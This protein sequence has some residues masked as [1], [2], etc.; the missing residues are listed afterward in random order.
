MWQTKGHNIPIEFIKHSIVSNRLAHAYLISGASYIGKTTFAL[1]IAKVVNCL[2]VQ[3]DHSPCEECRNCVRI[4]TRNH[5]DIH[6][7][8]FL[9]SK[10]SPIDQLREDFLAQVYKKPYEGKYK[11]FIISHIDKMRSEHS[12]LLLKTL[13]EPPE[14]V[15]IILIS[16]NKSKILGTILSRCQILDLY[17]ISDISLLK[18][19]TTMSNLSLSDNLDIELIVRL[20]R[21]RIGWV[22]RTISD[23]DLFFDMQDLLDDMELAIRNS[24]E[25]KLKFSNKLANQFK[26]NGVDGFSDIDIMITWWRDMMMIMLDNEKAI[27]NINRLNTLR[28]IATNFKL[29]QVIS[30]IKMFHSA[31]S[32]LNINTNPLL[33]YDNLFI[34]IPLVPVSSHY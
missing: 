2:N 27:I 31:K 32:H 17:P 29:D 15:I 20:S 23:P 24:I 26:T 4:S 5:T 1:D 18:S 11:I 30:I 6:I 21:G 28:D 19:V 8:D 16:E 3:E 9:N 33:V 14:D 12:N 34:N 10:D 7:L 22:Y 25:A 13:E